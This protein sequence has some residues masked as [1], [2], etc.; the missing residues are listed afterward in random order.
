MISVELRSLFR[1]LVLMSQ[2]E[3][4]KNFYIRNSVRS[5]SHFHGERRSASGLGTREWAAKNEVG[6]SMSVQQIVWQ[7]SKVLQALTTRSKLEANLNLDPAV[8]ILE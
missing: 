8:E 6:E 5:Q 7:P 4:F 2:F 3:C 1:F